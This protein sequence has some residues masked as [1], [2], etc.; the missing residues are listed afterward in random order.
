LHTNVQQLLGTTIDPQPVR[1]A[2][3]AAQLLPLIQYD[4]GINELSSG[5]ILVA[6]DNPVSRK[7]LVDMLEILGH[8][9]E[10]VASG[11]GVLD[12][13][14]KKRPELILLD[15]QMPQVDGY[16]VAATIRSWLNYQPQPMIVA[17]T[18]D[19]SVENR[20]RCLAAG[21][22]DYLPKPV[23]LE[24]LNWLLKHR[25]SSTGGGPA[26]PS[27]PWQDLSAE[28]LPIDPKV[29]KVLRKRGEKN[30]TFLESY[31][32]LFVE[33]AESRLKIL[34]ELL[35]L[36]RFDKF[37]REA[38]A[39]NG[40]CRQIGASGMVEICNQLQNLGDDVS[41]ER[42]TALFKRLSGEFARVRS[43]IDTEL[44]RSL[45]DLGKRSEGKPV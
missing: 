19:A 42:V 34:A 33:D 35:A 45:S 30:R 24:Q 1:S 20:N 2:I 29:W 16:T 21:M 40:G 6:E 39:L 9:A 13:M 5:G 22:D 12:V 10:S 3:R 27:L 8:P 41:V 18:A 26:A 32:K 15:C 31:M 36:A 4:D 11:Q 44:A 37:K 7:M 38:H 17:V 43:F 28:P 25:L 23:R 14:V